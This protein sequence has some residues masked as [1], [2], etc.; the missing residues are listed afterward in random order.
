V[1]R[2]RQGDPAGA[3]TELERRTA[4]GDIR[5][6]GDDRVDDGRVGQVGVSLVEALRYALAEVV[7]G[8]RCILSKSKRVAGANSRLSL[9]RIRHSVG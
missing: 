3:D 4:A 9:D 1:P 7:L 2:E 6:E 8:H 5:K